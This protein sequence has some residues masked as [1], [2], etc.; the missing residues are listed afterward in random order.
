MTEQFGRPE[1]SK[2]SASPSKENPET[3][4]EKALG[5]N[6]QSN[7]PNDQ[8]S[9]IRFR[10]HKNF[11]RGTQIGYATIPIIDIDSPKIYE[12][13]SE[14]INKFYNSEGINQTP[15]SEGTT[16]SHIEYAAGYWRN[17]TDSKEEILEEIVSDIRKFIESE[18]EEMVFE[19]R[20][21]LVSTVDMGIKKDCYYFLLKKIGRQLLIRP[22]PF[23]HTM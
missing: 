4:T 20:G 10:T 7:L 6:S 17:S 9:G 23:V 16:R 15:S 14:A 11:E 1:T 13:I 22:Q 21:N 18:K 2:D 19:L 8:E 5:D 12:H 3:K